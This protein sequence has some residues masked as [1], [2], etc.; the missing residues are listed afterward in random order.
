M[1]RSDA[2]KPGSPRLSAE[3]WIVAALDVMVDEGIGGVKIQRL[4]DRL[5]VTKGSFYWHFADLDTFLTEVARHWAESGAQLPGSID[6]EP[7]LDRR[8][9]LAMRLFANPRNRNLARAMRD[10]AQS[11]ERARAAIRKSDEAIFEQVKSALKRR[12]FEDEEAEVRAK[13]LYYSGVGYAHVGHLGRR[14]SAERQL[15]KTWELLAEGEG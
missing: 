14:D 8:L 4:C 15:M 9:L 3:D 5:G 1:P 10:W 13:I 7:D 12:G 2:P 6:D 11:D